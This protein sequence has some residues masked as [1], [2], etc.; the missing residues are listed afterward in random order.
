MRI[1][2]RQLGPPALGSQIKGP[3]RIGPEELCL[4]LDAAERHGKRYAG[5]QQVTISHPVTS[6]Q[7]PV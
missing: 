1:L 5:A 6:R 3:W 2:T 7:I 4:C